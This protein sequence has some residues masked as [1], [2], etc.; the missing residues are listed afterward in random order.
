M[1]VKQKPMI[2][3]D[4]FHKLDMGRLFQN[5]NNKKTVPIKKSIKLPGKTPK[6]NED[7]Y[8]AVN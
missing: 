8:A 1:G 6:N 2:S 5:M 4:N 3:V 7:K